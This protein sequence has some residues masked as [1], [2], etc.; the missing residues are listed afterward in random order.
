MDARDSAAYRQAVKT[1]EAMGE[2]PERSRTMLR[3][4]AQAVDATH[5]LRLEWS[6]LGYPALIVGPRGS[7]AV[8]PLVKA[9]RESEAHVAELAAALLLT[10]ESRARAV[11]SRGGKPLGASQSPDRRI[12]VVK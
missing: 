4:L 9:L 10:P 8:H 11:R 3:L 6:R 1:L 12:R 2:D 7:I 5:R